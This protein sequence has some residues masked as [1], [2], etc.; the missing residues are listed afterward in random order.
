MLFAIK[1]PDVELLLA[2]FVLATS[3]HFDSLF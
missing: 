3:S 2:L 1:P